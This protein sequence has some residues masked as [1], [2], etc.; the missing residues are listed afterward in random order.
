LTHNAAGLIDSSMTVAYEQYVLDDEILGAVLRV[1][2]GIRVTPET[3]AVEEICAVGPG[4]NFLAFEHTVHSM[5]S[6]LYMPQ[7]AVRVNYGAWQ[8]EGS[9]GAVEEA[10]EVA[11][12]ILA[13]YEVLSLSETVDNLLVEHFPELNL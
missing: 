6:E 1:L 2:Q 7:T 8:R 9:R 13:G 3:L 4:G 10:C 12:D 5:R 11:A